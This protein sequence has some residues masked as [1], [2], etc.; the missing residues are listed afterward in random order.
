MTE[1]TDAQKRVI[2]SN[3]HE[4]ICT[5]AAGSGKT[6][7]MIERIVRFLREGAEPASFLIM[8][9]T[10]A[11]AGEMREKLKKRLLSERK[12]PMIRK[13]LDQLD[14]MQIS[15]IHAFCQQLIKNQFQALNV[16]PDF[17][18]C[19]TSEKKKYFHQAFKDTCDELET[20]RNPLFFEL[21]N[22][23]ELE[24]AE[25][26]TGQLENF[27][28]TLPDPFRWLNEKIEQIPVVYAADHPW[29]EGLREITAE[30]LLQSEVVLRQMYDMFEQPFSLEAYRDS[31]KSDAELF[32]V[33]Q[34]SLRDQSLPIEPA[35]FEKL[36]PVRGLTIQESDW[37]DRYQVLRDNYKK[38]ILKADELLLATPEQTLSEWQSIKNTLTAFQL[39]V[40]RTEEKYRA[41]KLQKNLLEFHDL[42]QYAA[43]L[44]ADETVRKE[45]QNTWR[46]VFIDECQD[47]SAIQNHI[48]DMLKSPENDLFMVGDVKQSIYRFRLA[49]PGIFLR[50]IRECRDHPEEGRECITLQNNFRSRQEI[51]ETTNQIFRSVMREKTAEM[52]YGPEEELVAG[53]KT[54]GFDP[55]Q[56]IRIEKPEDKMS[57]LEATADFLRSEMQQLL[58]ERNPAEDRC[59][60]FRDMVILMPAVHPDGEKLAELLEARNIPVF[61]D[62]GGE[63]FE[64]TEVQVMKNLLSWIDNPMQDFPLISVLENAPFYFTDEE[65]A[66]IRLNHSAR[67]IP[68]YQAFMETSEQETLLGKK[69]RDVKEKL[70]QW[71]ITAEN[72]RVAKLLWKLYDETGYYYL[73]GADPGGDVRQANLRMLVQQAADAEKRGI[74]TIHRFISYMGDQQAYGDR[75][76][77]TPLGSQDDLVRIMTIHKS[78]GLQFPIVFCAGMDKSA[79]RADSEELRCHADL[80]ICVHFKDPDNRISR[81]TL[82]NAV[83]SWKKRHEETAEKIRLLYVA[84]TR[85]QEKLYLLT[86]QETNPVWAMPEGDA[87]VL[88][89]NCYTDWWMPI[90]D[91]ADLKK[92]STGYSHS[93]SPYEIRVF[94]ANQ[95]QTVDNN[96]NIHSLDSW[97]ESVLSIPPVQELWKKEK[98]V[99]GI[100][101]LRK[102]SVTALIREARNGIEEDIPEE[103]P[104][105]KRTSDILK[106][107][108]DRMEM[109][110][111]P[112]FLRQEGKVTPAWR[113]TMTHRVLSLMNLDD[114]RKGLSPEEAV[115]QEKARMLEH[116]MASEEELDQIQEGTIASFWRSEMGQRVLKAEEVHREWNFNLMIHRGEDVML[117]GIIDCA[118]REGDT[119]VILDYKTD[120]GKTPEQLLEEYL[121]QLQWYSLALE[122]L[123]GQRVKEMAL[124]SLSLNRLIPV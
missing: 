101:V 24:K 33:K 77:A 104:E 40:R 31:W 42:E 114:L 19:D 56:V 70:H 27:L 3:A 6:A 103:T 74:D 78:K 61:Y 76:S 10:N 109:P 121:P 98:E 53:R 49:E 118:F 34:S 67:E 30:T 60:Q 106:Q 4:L 9:F 105:M 15:T 87:R 91:S 102:K 20:E 55:V 14:L 73:V 54:E 26:M 16:D 112:A 63:Y 122:K 47:I 85:A 51:L 93:D 1:W 5:A 36:K 69:C 25:K 66:E 97:L 23:Y 29:F 35:A 81:P 111:A 80:G 92:S 45:V 110:E 62:G 39:L 58:L 17:Q 113:G 88:A 83:F 48:I 44:L 75:Q 65:L 89:G 32:H 43:E 79:V 52:D 37:K 82:A 123:T 100:P 120:R 59:W 95:Q 124:Y 96:K 99:K 71:Q 38:Q 86:C 68:F 108:L 107:R 115:R 8:T 64:T 18:I 46:Y 57:D 7:V 41:L 50:R 72:T 84:M 90:L 28:M 117:Q 12:N 116:H 13:A 119:W 11:A 21:K 94:E 2:Q 22:K